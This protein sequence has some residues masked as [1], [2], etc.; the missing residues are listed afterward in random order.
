MAKWMKRSL[1]LVLALALAGGQMVLPAMA[2]EDAV[3]A[4]DGVSE[5]IVISAEGGAE[6]SGSDIN[7][8][9]STVNSMETITFVQSVPENQSASDSI[10][11]DT[12]AEN[13]GSGTEG[14]A[15]NTGTD[16]ESG[17]SVTV[18]TTTETDPDTG[19]ET[20]TTEKI[21][22]QTES[23]SESIT[24][25]TT[26]T[27]TTW[28]STSENSV[29]AGE[30]P[31]EEGFTSEG[32]TQIIQTEGSEESHHE[33]LQDGPEYPIEESAKTEGSETTTT[34]VTETKEKTETTGGTTE[35]T[36]NDYT[37]VSDT[38]TG[39][40]TESQGSGED[41][42]KEAVITQDP[43]DVTLNLSQKDRSDTQTIYL[44]KAQ[45]V[46]DN[47]DL[48]KSGT[49]EKQLDDNTKEIV[50]VT[51]IYDEKN[52]ALV[53]G[54][55]TTKTI[56]SETVQEDKHYDRGET[57]S[58]TTTAAPESVTNTE[59]T[60]LMP[61]K[62]KGG[63]VTNADGTTTVTTVEEITQ[64]IL[65]EN[66]QVVGQEVVGYT[67]KK[68]TTS[69]DGLYSY[70][71]SES[72]YRTEINTTTD[73][74]TTARTETDTTQLTKDKVTTNSTTV[75]Y[76]AE[77]YELVLNND[78]WVYKATMSTVKE[79]QDNGKVDITPLTPT[80]LV[81]DGKSYVLNRSDSE[82]P[83]VD[84]HTSE[85]YEYTYTGVRGE[86]SQFNVI[87]D[88][89][90]G[91]KNKTDGASLAHMF[92]M[93][94]GQDTF[95]VYCLDFATTSIPNYNYTI[96]NVEDANYYKGVNAR[97]HIQAIGMNGYWGVTGTEEDG[98]T[99]KTG[100][101]EYMINNLK[102]AKTAGDSSLANVSMAQ[103]EGLTHGEA[104]TATQAAF[105]KYGN[106]GSTEMADQQ[107]NGLITAVYKWLINLEA[108][109]SD[110]TNIIEADEFAQTASI[111][112]K[113]QV[114]ENNKEKKVEGKNVYNTDVSFTID[115]AKSSL[116]GNMIISV[117]QNGKTMA[118]IDLATEEST[119]LGKLIAD[120]N[121][122]ST[123]VKF[124]NLELA[125][126]L[127]VNISLNG[128]QDLKE[129]VYIYTSEQIYSD[130]KGKVGPSQS[131]VGLAEGEQ[132]VNLSVDMSFSVSGPDVQVK[133][134]GAGPKKTKVD[135]LVEKKTDTETV[136]RT[137]DDIA[138]TTAQVQE[139]RRSWM[140]EMR[141]I[142]PYEYNPEPEDGDQEIVEEPDVEEPDIKKPAVRKVRKTN[143]LVNIPDEEV[144]L[145]KAPRTGDLSGLW[146]VISSLSLGGVFFLNR[147]RKEEE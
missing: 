13:T 65:D 136:T 138:V 128:T 123:T 21:V 122:K 126:G 116:T 3:P 46:E 89:G 42:V 80:T 142:W 60:Y 112:V 87:H 43:G 146:A 34:T 99:P 18:V 28:E 69:P 101:L 107:A 135:T 35:T 137:Y 145:A 78:K 24:L 50:E 15:E 94:I 47:I 30:N 70:S 74:E 37:T 132:T 19:A 5:N 56:I 4:D 120:E 22:T 140:K 53:I 76:D 17:A 57:T 63:T 103:I 119:W 125:E 51:Y 83:S 77:G 117:K 143:G 29:D 134:P 102:A 62:P 98:K 32:G 67:T 49:T 79:G 64:D 129:G 12:T 131:F 133:D 66:G 58:E 144:P 7:I 97:E 31:D 104:L 45:A 68:V 121:G 85:G 93:K 26:D 127:N 105:W 52:P 130:Y 41:A 54:Y 72:I 118:S 40:V 16:P 27:E 108:P 106:A 38:S 114:Y 82:I 81:L 92:E 141:Q 10:P 36:D 39:W 61:V 8:G 48:P 88:N 6:S 75:F 147:K 9:D 96:E 23:V 11:A 95:F 44:D 59:T 124:E 86:G 139:T 33:I 111:T 20:T 109:V 115:V 25:T 84:E 1:A 110:T 71:E 73:T 2:S 55:T 100:T 90:D 91:D 14:A 113:E